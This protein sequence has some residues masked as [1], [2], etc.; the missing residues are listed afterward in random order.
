MDF[1]QHQIKWLNMYAL[2]ADT[3]DR[4]NNVKKRVRAHTHTPCKWRIKREHA[5][6]IINKNEG[7][8][9]THKQKNE[10]HEMNFDLISLSEII[11]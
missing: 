3:M 10:M 5:L 9:N 2:C 4:K 11:L 7:Y 6:G 1:C 8:L